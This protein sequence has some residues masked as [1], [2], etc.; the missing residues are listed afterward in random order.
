MRREAAA[1]RHSYIMI[2]YS[3]RD[4]TRGEEQRYTV[5]LIHSIGKVKRGERE[6]EIQRER[7]IE[8]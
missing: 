1:K 5:R 6:R 4:K 8:R 3:Q 2:W 7:D